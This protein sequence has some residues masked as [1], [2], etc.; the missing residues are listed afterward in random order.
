MLHDPGDLVGGRGV[1]DPRVVG[2]DHERHLLLQ[3]PVDRVVPGL[4]DAADAAVGGRTDLDD[5]I[6]GPDALHG[7]VL[8]AP[9]FGEAVPVVGVLDSLVR[10]P[11]LQLSP[12]AIKRGAIDA[13]SPALERLAVGQVVGDLV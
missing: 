8:A 12:L 11:P 5:R 13:D 1:E 7:V 2:P 3:E 10:S 4:G 9:H 6:G